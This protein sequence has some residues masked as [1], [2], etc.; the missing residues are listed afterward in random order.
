MFF[1][2]TSHLF[3]DILT[4][5]CRRFRLA[6]TPPYKNHWHPCSGVFGTLAFVMSV[7][8]LLNIGGVTSIKCPIGTPNDVNEMTH[9]FF[10]DTR[11]ASPYGWFPHVGHSL[12]QPPAPAQSG[13]PSAPGR[14]QFSHTNLLPQQVCVCL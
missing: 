13:Q 14:Q 12:H 9:F 4:L 5:L 3:D 11:R 1:L 8:S 10:F 2:F 6:L 7:N